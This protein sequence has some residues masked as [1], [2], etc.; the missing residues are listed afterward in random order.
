M[1]NRFRDPDKNN[2][3]GF[4]EDLDFRNHN[5]SILKGDITLK[6]W[7]EHLL[8]I[9]ES[10]C[11]PWGLKDPRL[12]YLLGHYLE[13]CPSA[14]L[15]RTIRDA[16]MVAKSMSRCYGWPY[17]DSLHEAKKREGHLDLLLRNKEVRNVYF[18]CQRSESELIDELKEMIECLTIS[19]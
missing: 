4:W 5:I 1:G 17:M 15:V 9:M 6:K 11:E 12:C 14:L 13:F 2:P 18:N 7:R 3:D 10:R 8:E 19:R 16:H